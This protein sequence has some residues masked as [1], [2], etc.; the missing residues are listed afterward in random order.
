MKATP[1][2]PASVSPVEYKPAVSS[3]MLHGTLGTPSNQGRR[4]SAVDVW[5]PANP[6]MFQGVPDLGSCMQRSHYGLTNGQH[7]AAAAQYANQQQN[8]N[9]YHHHHHHYG[10]AAAAQMAGE[11]PYSLSGMSQ[12]PGMSNTHQMGQ[13]TSQHVYQMSGYGNLPSA[14]TLPR[15]NTQAYPECGD[16]KD[17]VRLL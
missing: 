14:N 1:P 13:V 5:N 2:P 3:P 7:A 10:T 6:A 8:Y 12:I 17:Y 11:S 15:P 4:D 9:N 16:Y